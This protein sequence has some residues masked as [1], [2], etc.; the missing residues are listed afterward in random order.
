MFGA[1]FPPSAA[2]SPC[3]S[4]LDNPRWAGFRRASTNRFYL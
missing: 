4:P 1:V 3:E 2:S